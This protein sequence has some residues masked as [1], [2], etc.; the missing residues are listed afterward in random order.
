MTLDRDQCKVLQEIIA[1]HKTELERARGQ[2]DRLARRL[3][4]CL[5]LMKSDSEFRP[6]TPTRKLVME[7]SCAALA[8][9]EPK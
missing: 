2:R 5:L 8:E 4:E 3:Q 6:M 9:L 1:A 7:D